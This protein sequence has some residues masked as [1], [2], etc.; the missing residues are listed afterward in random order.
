[1]ND[2]DDNNNNDWKKT[3]RSYGYT[4]INEGEK[5]TLIIL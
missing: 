5:V 3:M 4:S 1:M 2:D